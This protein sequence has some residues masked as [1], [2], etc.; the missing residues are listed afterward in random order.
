[1]STPD[2]S[3]ASVRRLQAE[4]PENFNAYAQLLSGEL[5]IEEYESEIQRLNERGLRALWFNPDGAH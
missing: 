5:M 1:M 2:M 4:Y 3:R